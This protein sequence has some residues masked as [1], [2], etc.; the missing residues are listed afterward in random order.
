MLEQFKSQNAILKNSLNYLPT[1]I[2]QS[3]QTAPS[4]TSGTASTQQELL[5]NVLLYNLTSS[6][7]LAP[8]I[9]RELL[10]LSGGPGTP[11][12]GG[13][14]RALVAA[15]VRAILRTKPIVDRLVRDL[16]QLPTEPQ[17]DEIDRAYGL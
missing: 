12:S 10:Q 13:P 7:E 15:H 2:G 1:L 16:T 8:E 3:G 17:A 14:D 5:R 11:T 4:S 6:E 9:D